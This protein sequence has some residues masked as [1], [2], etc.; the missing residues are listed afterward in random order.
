[1]KNY[2]WQ[3]EWITYLFKIRTIFDTIWKNLLLKETIYGCTPN[4][5]EREG[6]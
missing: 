2:F 1:M 5:L 4:G 6:R 3:D